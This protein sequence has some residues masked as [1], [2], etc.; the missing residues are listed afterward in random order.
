MK[1]K[2]AQQ[3]VTATLE[4]LYGSGRFNS[5]S[6]FQEKQFSMTQ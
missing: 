3:A 2:S 4:I 6:N 1:T 5:D